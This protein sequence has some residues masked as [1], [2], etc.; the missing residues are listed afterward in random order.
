[1][2]TAL[3]EK[4]KMPAGKQEKEPAQIPNY[5]IYEVSKGKPIYYKGYKEVLKGTKTLEEIKV[6]SILQ[7]WLKAYITGI[8]FIA[9]R[10]KP[11]DLMTGELG[12]NLPQQDKRGADISIFRSERLELKPFYSDI[13]PDIIIEIDLK[14]DPGEH[15]EMDYVL[16]KIQDYLDFGVQKVFW[17]FTK[18]KNVMIADSSLPWLTYDWDKDV[19][20]MEG[21]SFNLN[22]ILE[23]RKEKV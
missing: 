21:V 13:P 1:M 23:E 12:L 15:S 4:A 20:I 6:D 18:P 14:A 9:L 2:S 22:K 11:Y 3:V 7:S 19:E 16:Q 8:L 10:D 17:I 5:L